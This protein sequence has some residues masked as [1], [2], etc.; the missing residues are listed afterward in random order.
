[1]PD[2]HI[3]E[4]G[5]VV[6]QSGLTYRRA[7]LAYKTYGALDAA[8]SNVIVYPTSYGAQHYDLEWLIG[9]GKALDPSKYFII[10]MNK[11]GNG[12][13]S[14]PS[15]TSPPFDR[16]RYP[17]FTMTDNVRVQQRLLQEVFGIERV[18]LVYG[19][20]MG[21]QQAFHWAALFPDRV[22]RIAPVCGSAKTSRHNFVFL[23][24]V[25]AALTADPAWQDGWFATPPTRGF[26]AMPLER[27][28]QR[29]T[30]Q[31][32]DFFGLKDRG[33]IK[34]GYAADIAIFDP[35]TVGSSHRGERRYD[36]PG[37][38]KRMVMPS[39]GI[40]YTI[41]NGVV[42]WEHGAMTGAAAGQVLRG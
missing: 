22:E 18:K 19:F 5:D 38:A 42:T 40:E 30:A 37:G 2:Y 29:L 1:M 14:S 36:L 21:A 25:K 6:L 20:S 11:F 39:R 4:A 27:A 13:S 8:R 7:R 26:Q 31:P 9:E 12:L 32:A 17:H 35:E 3:F 28:V 34:P 15:N 16:G 33:R 23:E 41:V 10:I 24:G